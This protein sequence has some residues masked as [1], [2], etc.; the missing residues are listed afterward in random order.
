MKNQS[1]LPAALAVC[2]LCGLGGC[3]SR[4]P[5]VKHTEVLPAPQ[6]AALEAREPAVTEADVRGKEF[7]D[8]PALETVHFGY[9]QSVLE[10]T[11]RA[12]LQQNARWLKAH[13]AA[14]IQ[15]VGHCD[16]RGT[17]EYNLALGQRRA[18]TVREYYRYLGIPASRI[19]TLSMGK[20]SPLCEESSEAC[21]QRNRRAETKAER[22]GNDSGRPSEH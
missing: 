19:A 10:P 11:A 3:A 17:I 22:I 16:Q 1:V 18:S 14:S 13:P 12:A 4:K 20:E 15:I 2:L 9:D 6:T 21:W 7:A 5:A 8:H